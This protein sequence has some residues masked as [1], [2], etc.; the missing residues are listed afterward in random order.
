MPL[1][2]QE[3]LERYKSMMDEVKAPKKEEVVAPQAMPS[4][5]QNAIIGTESSGRPDAIG[6]VGAKA[7][8][9]RGLMQI[10]DTTARGLLKKGLLPQMWNGKKVK[11]KDLP[12]LLLDPEFN[13]QTGAALYEDNR[14][15]LRRS[16]KRKGIPLSPELEEELLIKAHNQG[17]TKTLR[18]DLYGEEPVNPKV[19]QY[20]KKIRDRSGYADGGTVEPNMF[21]TPDEYD[22][23]KEDEYQDQFSLGPVEQ[24][25]EPSFEESGISNRPSGL[26]EAGAA[27]LND[28][29]RNLLSQY[30][31]AQKKYEE[32]KLRARENHEAN[33]QNAVMTDLGGSVVNAFT[34]YGNKRATGKA[35]ESSGMRL[36]TPEMKLD[37]SNALQSLKPL[38][39][40]QLTDPATS[41][42]RKAKIL[43]TLDALRGKQ[44]AKDFTLGEGQIRYNQKGE[45]IASGPKKAPKATGFTLG[46]G[47]ERYDASGKLVAKGAP[48]EAKPVQTKIVKTMVGGQPMTKLINAS[49]GETV[50]EFVA[51]PTKPGEVPLSIDPNSQE[52]KDAQAK[53]KGIGFSI[54][55]KS[56]KLLTQSDIE[57]N[58]GG[59]IRKTT[60]KIETDREARLTAK[61]A[62]QMAEKDEVS[63]KQLESITAIDD[64]QNMVDRIVELKKDVKLNKGILG[65]KAKQLMTQYGAEWLG[66]EP[67]AA[68]VKLQALVE[69]QLSDYIKSASGLTVSD[70]EAMRLSRAIP[71]MSMPD[72]QFKQVMKE[73]ITTLKEVRNTRFNN[74]KG[75][76][77]KHIPTSMVIERE[78]LIKK[79]RAKFPK[80]DREKSIRYLKSKKRWNR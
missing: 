12:Q 60:R 63:D 62:W 35:M 8:D 15:V 51:A 43:K 34:D 56:L 10:Q 1:P 41:L 29:S 14:K 71:S 28:P 69:K 16:A 48:K 50:Q 30:E 9:S 13:K 53:L 3:E 47:Q 26:P 22:Q 2:F 27:N 54:D 78:G 57:S 66:I 39:Y 61:Q 32:D 33:R 59:F 38:D 4:H 72:G 37:K 25:Q 75:Y 67:D 77:G 58:L 42:E 18:R 20:L 21:Y 17:M 64:I 52:S 36:D 44:T 45:V 70:Q 46:Q 74:I 5:I 68:Y 65:P 19:Q 80:W 24:F 55:D 73:F 6:D 7:G 31:D 11:K 49:T 79:V 23:A 40:K 76:Q